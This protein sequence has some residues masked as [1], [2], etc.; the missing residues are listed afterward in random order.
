[1]ALLV[2]AGGGAVHAAPVLAPER[3]FQAQGFSVGTLPG[4]DLVAFQ[5]FDPALGTLDRVSVRFDAVL[6]SSLLVLPG[7]TLVPTIEWR[8]DALGLGFSFEPLSATFIFAPVSNPILDPTAPP[9]PL[10]H[11]VATPFDLSFSFTE[12]SDLAGLVI[13][14]GSAGGAAAFVPPLVSGRRADFVER[15][16]GDFVLEQL[17]FTS[18]LAGQTV[19]FEAGGLIQLEYVYT[20]AVAGVPEPGLSLAVAAGL[21]GLAAGARRS[22][23]G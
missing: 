6:V 10:V 7:Q 22:S 16:P 11:T 20:P 15:F 1:V 23:R 19:S 9:P 12:T 21:L 3:I 18:P 2:L 14:S 8:V 17:L 5:P 4:V 13:P